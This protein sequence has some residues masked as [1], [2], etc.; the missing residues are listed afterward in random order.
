M[1]LVLVFKTKLCECCVGF[2]CFTECVCSFSTDFVACFIPSCQ[3]CVH[4]GI[5]KPLH[6]PQVQRCERCV[7]FQSLAQC[8][9]SFIAHLVVCFVHYC[10]TSRAFIWIVLFSHLS[11]SVRPV[12]CWPLKLRSVHTFRC[13][14]TCLLFIVFGV[15]PW[16][17][18]VLLLLRPFQVKCSQC[19]VDL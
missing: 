2:H 1:L 18:I 19:C 14:W 5:V 7:D 4:L 10:S 11:G 17:G 13:H 12:L 16:F 9:R 8:T 15:A 3:N 6:A